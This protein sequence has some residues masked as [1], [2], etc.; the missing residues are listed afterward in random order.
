MENITEDI[1]KLL[2][3]LVMGAVIGAEREYKTKAAG[4]RTVTLIMVGSTLFTMISVIMGGP[5]DPARVASNILTGIGFIGAGTIF[6]EGSFVK[7]LTTAAVIWAAAA[8]GMAIGI[9]HYEFAVIG[10]V[11][12]MG[13][14]LGFSWF[15][16]IIDKSNVNKVYKITILGNH[17]DKLDEINE[18]F[19]LYKL[20]FKCILQAKRSNEMV[21]SYSVSGPERN[22]DE[23]VKEFYSNSIINSFE[24][25]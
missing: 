25:Y 7:G 9:G 10:L 18:I 8:I 2:I 23:L 3:A 19:V 20:K 24:S 12:V 13:V 22:H 15:Q 11:I 4:F 17:I 16:N 6:K 21:L 14:L 1:V 5:E